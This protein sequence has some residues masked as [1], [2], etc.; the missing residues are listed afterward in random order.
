MEA[1]VKLKKGVTPA[2]A[3]A[4]KFLKRLDSRF[5]GNDYLGL[6]QMTLFIKCRE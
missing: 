2:K 3:G 5:R 1:I 4:Q 6:L